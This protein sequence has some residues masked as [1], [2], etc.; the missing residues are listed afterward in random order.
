[1]YRGFNINTNIALFLHDSTN[2]IS[3]YEQK[4]KLLFEKQ[5]KDTFNS[6]KSFL[7][8]DG[9]I[10]GTSLQNHWFP[11]IKADI[12]IS[13]SHKDEKL[14]IRLAGWI[15]YHFG[16]I[17]FI[18]S[19]LWGY[20]NNLLYEINQSNKVE[21]NIYNYHKI[22]YASSHVN[23]ML[24]IALQNMMDKTECLF[25]LNT[26]SSVYDITNDTTI[27]TIS[28][29]IYYELAI[30]KNLRVNTPIRRII[31]RQ[32]EYFSELS[33]AL[34]ESQQFIYEEGIDHLKKINTKDLI[35]WK[36]YTAFD[37]DNNY[38]DVLYDYIIK[39]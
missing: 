17:S 8:S 28:P 16:L 36:S 37:Q 9:K 4:G 3:Y 23:M 22:L 15:Y 19:C 13:H 29:W 39:E 30:S 27:R 20:S 25:F 31:E 34:N 38:L 26:S 6:L 12:F 2:S 33:K 11:E 32:T 5:K 18:D 1:M 14:A 21:D 7:D 10:D 35:A 24:A